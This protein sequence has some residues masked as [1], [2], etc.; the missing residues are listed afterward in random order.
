MRFQKRKKE[1][2]Q[3]KSVH[4]VPQPARMH[5]KDVGKGLVGPVNVRFSTI[6]A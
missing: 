3:L 6:H 1:N 4:L 5:M 2:T